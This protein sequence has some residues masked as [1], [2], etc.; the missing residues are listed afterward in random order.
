MKKL[1]LAMLLLIGPSCQ[2]TT[3]VTG[4]L[5]NLGTGN[6]TTG[7]FVRF[8]LRGCGGNQPRVGGTA[9]IAP[10]QG[11]SYF[12]DLIANGSG[13]I[14][15]TLYSTRD[16]TGLLGGDI[17]CG[18]STTSVWYGLQVFVNG[19]GGPEVPI[20]A[21]NGVALDISNITP[22]STTPVIA[23]PTG[24]STYAR[25]DGG[26]QPFTTGIQ[27]PYFRT[28]TAN[29]AQSGIFRLSSGDALAFRNNANGADISL[30]KF[31]AASG[32][33]PAD[34]LQ[35]GSGL[36]NGIGSGFFSANSTTTAAAGI[37]RLQTGDT[38]C[39]RNNANS[40]DAC[41]SKNSSDNLVW[42]NSF[43]I[44]GNILG[45]NASSNISI[46][47]QGSTSGT[48]QGINLTAQNGAS[49]GGNGGQVN[50]TGGNANG[51][52]QGGSINITPGTG[53]GGQPNGIVNITGSFYFFPSSFTN[54]TLGTPS[55]GAVVFCSDCTIANP[56]A[57]GGTGAIAKRLNG[58][59]VCN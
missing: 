10:T 35:Y 21:K 20:H 55:N 53:G 4:T 15:G 29:P 31:G 42:P 11:G 44:N 49:S 39:W 59:W 3:T 13:Q 28:S 26:N 5:Q 33:F 32:N 18:T 36:S 58:I 43:A 8:W 52:A 34:T 48:G 37:L 1:L 23:A 12:F 38:A 16:A 2:A 41:L 51:T 54:G 50:L 57:G 22:I 7:A 19:K 17:T 30:A 14:S 27:S 56:C 9:L 47:A 6:I 24:D 25:L 45:T 40:A 46:L